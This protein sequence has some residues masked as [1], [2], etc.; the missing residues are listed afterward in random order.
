M[1]PLVSTGFG[2]VLPYMNE[3]MR[4]G[5][6]TEWRPTP[7]ELQAELDAYRGSWLDEM[8]YRAPGSFLMETVIF[9]VFT[10]WRAGG[11]MLIG[12]ALFKL[13]VFNSTRSPRFYTLLVAIGGAIGIGVTGWGVRRNI[14]HDWDLSCLFWGL[15]FN[16]FGSLFT[17]LAWIGLVMLICQAKALPILTNSLA[18]VGQTAFSN[19]ILQ[20]VL[21]TTIFYGHGFGLFGKVD[22]FSQF[23]LVCAIWAFQLLVSAWWIRNFRA[24][25]LEWIWRS[26][27]YWRRQPFRKNQALPND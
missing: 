23:L 8:K 24:G 22:R 21:C 9:A 7:E 5:I 15:N 11:L 13:E 14:A 26:L 18:A 2:L 17:S 20:T 4:A 16:Y 19:Y 3:E 1:P 25:P 6:E 12:M 10:M 27:T